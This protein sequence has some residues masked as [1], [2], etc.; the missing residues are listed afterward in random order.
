MGSL[1]AEIG[2]MAAILVGA[3]AAKV[4]LLRHNQP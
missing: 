1:H 3:W 2:I 4:R